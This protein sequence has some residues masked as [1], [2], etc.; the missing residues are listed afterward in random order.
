MAALLVLALLAGPLLGQMPE[1][2][3]LANGPLKEAL[4]QSARLLEREGQGLIGAAPRAGP[5]ARGWR[6]QGLRLL[7]LAAQLNEAA[8]G[9]SVQAEQAA[10]SVREYSA[11][12]ADVAREMLRGEGP[13]PEAGRR[14]LAAS[15][16]LRRS[17][18][19]A[20]ATP[21]VEPF[22][23]LVTGVHEI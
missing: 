15:E 5:Q 1:G 9:L 2:G 7:E 23:D 21:P 3:P 17:A 18:R 8:E 20:Q 11:L 10:R 13:L 6:S 4:L 22:R 16:R 19:E 12:V 14:V